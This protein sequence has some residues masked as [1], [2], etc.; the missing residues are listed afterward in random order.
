MEPRTHRRVRA[1]QALL[2][3][4]W[5]EPPLRHVLLSLLADTSALGDPI[6]LTEEKDLAID[7]ATMPAKARTAISK[8]LKKPNHDDF[9]MIFHPQ[10]EEK[11]ANRLTMTLHGDTTVGLGRSLTRQERKASEKAAHRAINECDTP[12]ES[13]CWQIRQ[14]YSQCTNRTERSTAYSTQRR[15][16][17]EMVFEDLAIDP[18]TMPAKARTAISKF[19]K[20]PNHYDFL[21]IFHP[22]LEEKYA[23]RLTM[24]LHGDATV[25][26]GRSL[27]RQRRSGSQGSF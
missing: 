25:G 19:L 23:N 16:T 1:L 8:F 15:L 11:Y 3:G 9:L 6:L 24:T 5:L 26:L 7:P 4:G 27:A 2:L 10:L 18:A 17:E 14:R 22:Q 21:M 12:K 13:R 20:K